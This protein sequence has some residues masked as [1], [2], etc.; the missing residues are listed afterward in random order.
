MMLT[1]G[2]VIVSVVVGV[3][4]GVGLFLWVDRQAGP[5]W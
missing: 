3:G 4:L 2:L 1:V 5:K